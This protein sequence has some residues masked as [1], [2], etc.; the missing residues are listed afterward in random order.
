MLYFLTGGI[1]TGKTRWLEGAIGELAVSGVPSY[2]VIAPGRW[3]QRGSGF[4]KL[5]IDNVLLPHGER[6]AF[7]EP[8]N[9]GWDFNQD[10]IERVNEH[11][12]S[13]A[14]MREL[15]DPGLL[16]IDELGWMELQKGVGLVA[17]M[18][19]LDAGAC[20]TFSHALAVV[21]ES[22]L[23]TA[24]ERFSS[25]KWHGLRAI[26]PEAPARDELLAL[27]ASA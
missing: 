6:L 27:L 19:L 7:A 18:E 11:M 2:G 15:A 9:P 16:V 20:P 10:A 13:L 25:A 1:Q 12:A 8:G 22:L 23:P 24:F 4:E 17:A 21:R 3:A 14:D 5:G 26:L